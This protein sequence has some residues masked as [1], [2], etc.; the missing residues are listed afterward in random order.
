[1]G[2]KVN[3]IVAK[4][5]VKVL[6]QIIEE[7]NHETINKIFQ[8]IYV[9]SATLPTTHGRGELEQIRIVVNTVLYA[10]ITHTAYAAPANTGTVPNI[11][12]TAT[13]SEHMQKRDY[14]MVANKVYKNHINTGTDLKMLIINAVEYWFLAE[15]RNR[16]TGYLG[17]TAP[18]LVEHLVWRYVNI[19]TYNMQTN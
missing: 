4:F 8:R 7:R 12:G 14:H 3:D 1:M 17:A 16:Y 10:T 15:Q 5:P 18:K 6:P 19:T 2:S 9:N 13:A 11:P